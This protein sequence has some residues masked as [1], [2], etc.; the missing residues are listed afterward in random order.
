MKDHHDSLDKEAE[1]E[2]QSKERE[3]KHKFDHGSGNY[4]HV[5][6]KPMKAVDVYEENSKGVIKRKGEVEQ[7]KEEILEDPTN[8]KTHH[9]HKK[10][11][12]SEA[13]KMIEMVTHSFG[14]ES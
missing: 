7:V 11:M 10:D 1:T 12:F 13:D 3:N 14:K 5:V 4:G 8:V 2:T 6:V 9:I